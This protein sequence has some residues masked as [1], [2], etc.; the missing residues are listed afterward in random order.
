MIKLGLVTTKYTVTKRG[1]S[2]SED[3][4]KAQTE[5]AR[6]LSKYFSDDEGLS[7]SR[8]DPKDLDDL[9]E[10][11]DTMKNQMRIADDWIQT[12]KENR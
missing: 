8:T 6:L 4:F 9:I 7:I 11:I 3:Y 2:Y 1:S 12:Q 10:I 5:A